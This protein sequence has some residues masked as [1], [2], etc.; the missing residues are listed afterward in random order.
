M[1]K[2]RKIHAENNSK[3]AAFLPARQLWAWSGKG[4]KRGGA[5][6]RG[7]KQFFKS[8]QRGKETISVKKNMIYKKKFFYIFFVFRLV[9][10][11]CFCQLADQT[12]HTLAALSRC[13]RQLQIIGWFV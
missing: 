9:I 5:K 12:D 8:I 6:G 3:I 1:S 2:D 13:G 7:K 4:I 10:V 11:L